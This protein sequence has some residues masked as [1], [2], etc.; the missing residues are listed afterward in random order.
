M[1]QQ[2][3]GVPSPFV[4]KSELDVLK[5]YFRGTDDLLLAMRAVMLNIEPSDAQKEMVKTAFADDVLYEAVKYRFLPH[6]SKDVPIGQVQDIWLGIDQQLIGQNP[7][8]IKQVV[9]LNQLS[10]A[11]VEKAL[12]CLKGSP[13]PVPSDVDIDYEGDPYATKLLAR[14]R[15]VRAIET[16]LLTLKTVSNQAEAPKDAQER[17]SSR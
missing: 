15:F 9:E 13:H 12:M 6:L 8:T 17:N 14:N 3:Q 4:K 5:K 7:D 2:T 10:I 1:N 11:M 16:Q